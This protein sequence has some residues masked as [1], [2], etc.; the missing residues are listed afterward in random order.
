VAIIFA[1]VTL[2][3][4]GSPAGV[5]P[6]SFLF[7]NLIDNLAFWVESFLLI[8]IFDPPKDESDTSNTVKEKQLNHVNE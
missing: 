6:I 2:V 8:T 1:A 4:Y 3:L 7:V 5:Q